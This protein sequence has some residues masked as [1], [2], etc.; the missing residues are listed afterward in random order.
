MPG[1]AGLISGSTVICVGST[2]VSYTVPV[3]ENA[4]GYVWEV[5][6]GSSIVSGQNTN[7]ILVDFSASAISG[8]ISVF[9]TNTYGNGI[10]SMLGISIIP[11]P[12]AA[13]LI[14][15]LNEVCNSQVG[16]IY[17]VDPIPDAIAYNWI[18][19]YGALITDGMN[20]NSITVS[21]SSSSVAGEI[22]VSGSNNCG[23]GLVSAPFH[24]TV[25]TSPQIINQPENTDG[26]IAD[27][28]TGLFNLL[29]SGTGLLYRWQEFVGTWNDLSENAMYVGVFTDT[30]HVV[31]PS[32]VM[33]GNRYRCVVSGTC[34]PTAFTDGNATLVVLNPVGL[35]WN[36]EN[37]LTLNAYPNPFTEFINIEVSFPVTGSLKIELQNISGQT[38]ELFNEC[39]SLA[40][41]QIFKIH[42]NKLDPGLYTIVFTLQTENNL[43]IGT[44]KI[45]CN[46]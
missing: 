39:V 30:L 45:I 11:Q 19:P 20:T 29:A 46:H 18:I 42:A 26:V 33:N 16:V 13:G 7:S 22:T 41:N 2:N 9:G 15:G 32:L 24:V 1:D 37:I 34:D 5:P 38:I 35:S 28:G 23:F 44:K 43:M 25:N 27:S 14:S 17:T 4:N 3:I 31:N 10:P 36:F 40:G 8:T 12:G 6:D 21:Y